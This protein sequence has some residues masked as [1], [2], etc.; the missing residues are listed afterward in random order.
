MITRPLELNA[1]EGRKR[2]CPAFRVSGESRKVVALRCWIR[3][4]MSR[5][6]EGLH[7]Q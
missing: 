6:T 7:A 3:E 2:G 5:T 1:L 4:D